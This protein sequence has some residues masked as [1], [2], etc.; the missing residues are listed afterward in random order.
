MAMD[1]DGDSSIDRDLRSDRLCGRVASIRTLSRKEKPPASLRG[2]SYVLRLS[3]YSAKRCV[4]KVVLLCLTEDT[5]DL[6]AADWA[7]ALCHATT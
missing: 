7:D 3:A 5:V 1:D 4:R 6:G 2:V